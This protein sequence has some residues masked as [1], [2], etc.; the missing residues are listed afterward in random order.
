MFKL[1]FPIFFLQRYK[2]MSFQFYSDYICKMLQLEQNIDFRFKNM[3]MLMLILAFKFYFILYL[4]ELLLFL[5]ILSFVVYFSIFKSYSIFLQRTAN[6]ITI[7]FITSPFHDTRKS[8][9]FLSLLFHH[10]LNSFQTV[11]IN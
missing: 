8:I 4:S 5:Y 10:I 7:N 1:Y 11:K 2:F 6:V 9:Q 3:H